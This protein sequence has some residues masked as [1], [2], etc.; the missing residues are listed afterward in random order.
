MKLLLTTAAAGLLALPA[1]AE[2][3]AV[4]PATLPTRTAYE[5]ATLTPMALTA[6]GNPAV[7]LLDVAE[8]DVVPAHAAGSGLR[9]ITVVS[10]TLYWGDGDTVE[11]ASERVYPAGSFLVLPAGQMHWVAARDS[12]LRLQLVILDDETPVPAIAGLL[13]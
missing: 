2:T 10:G 4:D 11:P 6:E 13:D 9:L 5:V 7:V 8:G 1:V 3:L 12:A